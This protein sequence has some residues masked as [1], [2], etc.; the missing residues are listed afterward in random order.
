MPAERPTVR[1]YLVEPPTLILGIALVSVGGL[2][3]SRVMTNPYT[4]VLPPMAL[5]GACFAAL[6]V[7]HYRDPPYEMQP[8]RIPDLRVPLLTVGLGLAAA[9]VFTFTTS[10]FH[11]TLPVHLLQFALYGVVGAA[12]FLV[13]STRLQ[14]G[15]V[16]GASLLHRATVYYASALPL[17]LDVQFHNRVAEA[18]AATGTM[19][20]LALSK[21]WYAPVYHLTTAVGYGLFGLPVRDAA[22][23]TTTLFVTVAPVLGIYAILQ[24]FWN[25]RLAVVGAYL[26][27][28]SDYAV[29]TSVLPG[30][31][32]VGLAV[33]VLLLPLAIRY[34]QDGGRENF[35]GIVGLV[36]LLV[37]THQLTLFIAAVAAMAYLL[38]LALWRGE[39]DRRELTLAGLLAGALVVQWSVTRY[40]GP[41]G[42]TASFLAVMWETL[43]RTLSSAT[44]R[45]AALPPET[46]GLV[47][48]GA[49]AMTPIH[50]VGFGLLVCASIIGAI[51]WVTR[52]E[53][54]VRECGIGLSA[55][56]VVMTAV[57]FVGPLFGIELLIPRRWF[58]FL[59]V[60]LVI[61]AVPGLAALVA[62]LADLTLGRLTRRS[63]LTLAIAF[64][65]LLAPYLVV[66]GWNY[67]GAVDDPVFD[68][69]PGA[70][71]LATTEAEADLYAAVATHAGGS[72]VV[73]DHVARQMIDRHYGQSAATYRTVYGSAGAVYEGPQLLVA[74][75]Y[76]TTTHTSYMVK[77]DGGW[78][79]V[80][81]AVPYQETGSSVV[82]TNG[83][84]RVLYRD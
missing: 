36:T 65:V 72:M 68:D 56:V 12:V 83:Q 77:Y 9:T 74:R 51:Y 35:V 31:T 3:L 54:R 39:F 80:F 61:L 45:S 20:P 30:P 17:G 10:G 42:D 2:V 49:D 60:P 52:T 6:L 11:R 14:L 44:V 32:S 26:Y 23:L 46:T 48:S 67:P 25:A 27:L 62:T 63:A 40:G 59:Y 21:Y 41:A 28:L 8:D 5:L 73:A 82:Y 70:H 18:I 84:D 37:L 71:R 22:F 75:E 15:L 29:A 43:L 55:A 47:V 64:L 53:G 58:R 19:A 38:G 69:A 76:A 4:V 78:T 13:A 79:R 24:H 16:L 81:G 7:Y 57:V 34:V 50:V 33:F 1:D 66:M